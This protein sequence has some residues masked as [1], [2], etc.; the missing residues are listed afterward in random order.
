M[1]ISIK[2]IK[3]DDLINLTDLI[4]P[5]NHFNNFIF[6]LQNLEGLNKKFENEANINRINEST[7]YRFSPLAGVIKQRSSYI[8]VIKI[9]KESP[10]FLELLLN[11]SPYVTETISLLV[12]NKGEIIEDKIYESLNKDDKFK[13]Y[14]EHKKRLIIKYILLFFRFL[15]RY[16]TITINR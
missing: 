13:N 16:L 8:E 1:V 12:D 2:L 11:V 5:L 10:T 15:L 4:L 7:I 6:E 3:E 14:D 9:K